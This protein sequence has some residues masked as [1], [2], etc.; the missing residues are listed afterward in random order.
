LRFSLAILTDV[1]S[2][3]EPYIVWPGQA[4]AYKVGMIK[5]LELREKAKN[6]LGDKYDIRKFHNV[7]LSSGSV[8]L[9]ILENMVNEYIVNGGKI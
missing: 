7:V 5:I 1:E 3:I 6:V 9:S 8:P 2:E 4:L